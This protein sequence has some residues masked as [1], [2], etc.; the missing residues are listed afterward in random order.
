MSILLRLSPILL[1][2]SSAFAFATSTPPTLALPQV[3]TTGRV[4]ADAEGW[5]A[6]WPGITLTTRFKGRAIGI[7]V[8]DP[9]SA[10][11]VELDG[12]IRQPLAMTAES[13]TVWLRRLS[14]ASHE[15]RLTRRN[16]TTT[17][18]GTI[19]AFL[20][21][22]GA[23]LPAK[24]APR[25]Q[26][27]FI[28][29]SFTAGLADLSRRRSCNA[30]TIRNTS[31]ATAAF[32]VRVARQFHASWEINAMSGMGMVRNWNGNLPG[33]NFRTYY[34]R[35]L[36]SDPQSKADNANWHPQLV[37]IGLGIND[38][39]TP[40]HDGEAWTRETLAAQFKD[41][42]RAL[43][44]DLRERY[45]DADIVATAVRI[46]PDDQQGTLVQEVV[47]AAR[48][49]GDQHVYYLE[50]AG[51]ELTACQWHPNLADHKKMAQ[52]LIDLL[53]ELHPFK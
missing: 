39:S 1:V 22:N 9:L 7:V 36:Q 20:L 12:A 42:Y 19:R 18:T 25:R 50:Y 44:A 27:E 53:D 46:G 52:S 49:E 17:G 2:L 45:G 40:L 38:F 13:H 30:A 26:I 5:H 23:W 14:N 3:Q 47:D 21:E 24:P 33:E 41:G 28:G 43:M 29:D 16:E 35:L 34:P 15:L 4:L 8:D 11:T 10:Y 51:L 48:A 31:D 32:G 37:V 6:T